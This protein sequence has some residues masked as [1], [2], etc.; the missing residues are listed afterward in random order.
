M[1][2]LLLYIV[3]H[4]NDHFDTNSHGLLSIYVLCVRVLRTMEGHEILK[5]EV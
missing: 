4:V 1:D 3:L 5:A 2:V